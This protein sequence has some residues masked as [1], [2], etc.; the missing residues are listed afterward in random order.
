[1]ISCDAEGAV[2]TFAPRSS[3]KEQMQALIEDMKSH[4]EAIGFVVEISDIYP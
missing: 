3:D 2:V 1:M 4:Y